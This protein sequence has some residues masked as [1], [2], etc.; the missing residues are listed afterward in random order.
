MTQVS[1]DPA[2]TP[3][4][5]NVVC[6]TIVNFTNFYQKQDYFDDSLGFAEEV[7]LCLMNAGTNWSKVITLFKFVISN[8]ANK[9]SV[10]LDIVPLFE[11]I[12]S[13]FKKNGSD[14]IQW[15]DVSI[16]IAAY[17]YFLDPLIH[18]S[19]VLVGYGLILTPYY[20]L[21]FRARPTLYI[22]CAVAETLIPNASNKLLRKTNRED[23]F[24]R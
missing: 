15:L 12:V 21:T 11:T 23:T 9:E 10:M 2:L 22:T 20:L 4:V 7:I 8:A 5:I 19:T 3:E 24:E 18:A 16:V 14:E 6:E 1:S 13:H 17:N